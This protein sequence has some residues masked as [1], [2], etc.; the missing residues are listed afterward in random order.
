M[1]KKQT[2]VIKLG[3]SSLH[4]LKTLHELVLLVRGYRE[5][6]FDV[7][8]VHGGGPA[9]NQALTERGI[10]WQFIQGQRQTTPEMMEVIEEVLAGTVNTMV[11]NALQAANLAA[12]GLSGAQGILFCT[13]ASSELMQVGKIENVAV[14][15]ILQ[16]LS[17]ADQPVPVIAPIGRGAGGEL[18]NINADWAAAKIA[19]ALQAE[20]LVFLTDQNGVLDENRQLVHQASPEKFHQM[21]A[22]GTI[23]G[24]MYTKVMTMM[25]ALEAGVPQVRVLNAQVA[26]LLLSTEDVGTLLTNNQPHTNKEVSAWTHRMI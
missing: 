1:M 3:G 20:K 22:E 17:Q 18:Y 5:E 26:S 4:N 21:I 7:V 15:P 11:V 2:V 9:I 8:V 6:N 16:A 25:T 12:A 24:G 14:E 13:Q 19:V 23:V 10:T